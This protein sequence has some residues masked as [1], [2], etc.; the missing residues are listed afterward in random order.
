MQSMRSIQL[1]R[2]QNDAMCINVYINCITARVQI[3]DVT[4]SIN[5][6]NKLN[7][8]ISFTAGTYV[9]LIVEYV[10]C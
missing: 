5:H 3:A 9:V 8:K 7:N 6:S 10:F 1:L 4:V 2:L